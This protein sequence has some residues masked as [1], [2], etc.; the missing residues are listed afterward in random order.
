MIWAGSEILWITVIWLFSSYMDARKLWD[1]ENKILFGTQLGSHFSLLASVLIGVGPSAFLMHTQTALPI[2]PKAVHGWLISENK[3]L[4]PRWEG[5]REDWGDGGR[6][7][8]FNEKWAGIRWAGVKKSEF[9]VAKKNSGKMEEGVR[10]KALGWTLGV[11]YRPNG[12]L[13]YTFW[14][15]LTKHWVRNTTFSV[16]KTNGCP[17]YRMNI[18]SDSGHAEFIFEFNMRIYLLFSF[19]FLPLK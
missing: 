17:Y 16:S 5:T 13:S 14:Q 10:R 1:Q 7:L 18:S 19:H 12:G 2:V 9:P 15:I 4:I 11:V 6:G 3:S 8:N